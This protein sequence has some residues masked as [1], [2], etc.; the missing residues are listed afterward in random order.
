MTE[1]YYNSWL[2]QYKRPFGAIKAGKSVEISIDCPNMKIAALYFV[3]RKEDG[4]Q[5]VEQ[6]LMESDQNGRYHCSYLLSQGK[7]LYYYHFMI[8][9]RNDE[10]QLE[11][12]FYGATKEHGGI[13]QVYREDMQ[14]IP[15]QLT[16]FSTAEKAPTWYREAVFYQI[17][18]DRFH[19]GNPHGQIS[20]PKKNSFIYGN[21]SDEPMYVKNEAGEIARWDFQGGNLLGIIQ[22]IPYLKELGVNAIYLNPIFES[23]S[24]H[25]YD[26][27]DYL[28]IDGM[29]GDEVIFKQLVDTLHEH[30]MYLILDGVFNHVGKNSRYFNYDGS[31]GTKTGAYRNSESLY[32]SWFTFIDYP[33]SYESWWGIADLPQVNKENREFQEFIYGKTNSVLAKWNSFGIDGWRLDVADELPD[34]FIQGIRQNLEQ[35]TEKILLG[36]VWEDA[37][38]K[39]A[40]NQRRQYILGDALH[41]VM[42]YPLRTIILS[43]LREET[44]TEISAKNLTILEENYPSDI[45]MNNLNNLGTHDTERLLT[46]MNENI[47]KMLS[48]FSLMIVLPGIPCLYYGDEA[49]LTGGKDP[50]NRKYFPWGSEELV[51]QTQIKKWIDIRKKSAAL[52]YGNVYPFYTKDLFGILRTTAK[53]YALYILNPTNYLKQINVSEFI[54]TKQ[55]PLSE[56]RVGNMLEELKI[57][58]YDHVFISGEM[59]TFD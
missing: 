54:F 56:E 26:T 16:C 38:N 50:E 58:P 31:Y 7:G 9:T 28:M 18:P 45:F 4:D 47:I 36:E 8:Q 13:G 40:Y 43:L 53:E 11:T 5:G 19:N 49:G 10:N 55:C 44:T 46:M 30:D 14:L 22:K 12:F 35:Y 15:Y 2:E 6:Y 20:Q 51:I 17:F 3:I 39:I 24:N 57:A 32:Y 29:L 23:V 34:F 52:K 25:R 37:S 33:K 48:A 41:G 21:H 59:E 27:A 42:N 1:F